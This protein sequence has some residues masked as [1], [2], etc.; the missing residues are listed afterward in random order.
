MTVS[1]Y[2]F[3]LGWNEGVFGRKTVGTL[4]LPEPVR[5]IATP[6]VILRNNA[7]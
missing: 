7:T 3:T 1:I 2:D 4:A 5:N 6:L